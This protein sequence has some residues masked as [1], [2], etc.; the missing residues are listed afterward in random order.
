MKAKHI[1]ECYKRWVLVCHIKN[2]QL[3]CTDEQGAANSQRGTTAATDGRSVAAAAVFAI[4]MYQQSGYAPPPGGYGPPGGFGGA[5]GAPS[6]GGHAPAPY[7]AAPQQP[8]RQQD[9]RYGGKAAK[10]PVL[11]MSRCV[12]S[13][14]RPCVGAGVWVPLG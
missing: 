1:C 11:A 13:R 12:S 7:H 3:T 8:I 5:P 6:F 2:C 14:W 10:D 4:S 9:D